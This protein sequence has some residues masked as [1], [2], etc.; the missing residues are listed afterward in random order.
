MLSPYAKR[1][2]KLILSYCS[3]KISKDEYWKGVK[4]IEDRQLKLFPNKEE[5][6][7]NNDARM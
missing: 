3:G 6:D 1:C 4:E 2:L 7:G 5:H